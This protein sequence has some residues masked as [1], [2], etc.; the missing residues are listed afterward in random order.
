MSTEQ[1]TA[2]DYRV[3]GININNTTPSNAGEAS[4]KLGEKLSPEFLAK[5]FPQEYIAKRSTNVAL[6][7][8][9]VLQTYGKLGWE[10]YHQGQLGTTSLLFFRKKLNIDKFKNELSDQEQAMIS[11][12]DILQRP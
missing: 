9:Q 11:Q 4:K 5:E 12:L 2:W 8:Q 3:I 1:S 6:Q 7:C 10:H